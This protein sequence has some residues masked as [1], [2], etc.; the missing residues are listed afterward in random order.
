MTDPFTDAPQ[1]DTAMAEKI[2]TSFERQS[3]M[4]TLGAE[5]NAL[6]PGLC[7]IT[8]P[9]LPGSL[10]QHGYGHAGLTFSIAD[11]AAGYAALSL[12]G[13][14]DDVLSVELKI[15]LL[16][17]ARGPRL[18]AVG[19]VVKSGRKLIVIQSEVWSGEG[20]NLRQIGLMQ[21]TMIPA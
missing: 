21:G 4:T 10:Q 3:L 17:P 16:A 9:L 20:D 18:H 15:N 5:L 2:R 1:L 8:A 12:M 7:R 6:A 11:S 19:R 13:L 14:D